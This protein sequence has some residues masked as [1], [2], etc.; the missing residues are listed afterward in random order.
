[1]TW[2]HIV[3]LLVGIALI[4]GGAVAYRRGA[5]Q[6]GVILI[7]VGLLC[8]VHGLGLLGFSPP[9]DAAEQT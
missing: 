5:T 4:A 2:L 6:G 1:M 7:F 3:S 9:A 8:T